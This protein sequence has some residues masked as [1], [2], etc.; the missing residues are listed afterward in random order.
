MAYQHGVYVQEIPTSVIPP[1]TA[2]S[3]VIFI[4]GTAPVNLLAD[5]AGAVNKLTLINSFAEAVEKLGYSDSFDKF[6]IC[7][8]LDA[9]FRVYNVAPIV[10][11]N[12]LDPAVH[13]NAVVADE[14]DIVAKKILIEEEGILFDAN[15][16]VVGSA[17]G[18]VLP[19]IQE[20]TITGATEGTFKLG[21]SLQ[22]ITAALDHDIS[23]VNLAAAINGLEG[24]A[25]A[26]VSLLENVY[27]ITYTT[28][29]GDSGIIILDNSLI[30]DPEPVMT[31]EIVQ[32]YVPAT[33][34]Y[35]KD[36]DYSLEFTDD[37]YA[38]L[39]VI[40]E[41]DGGTI[42]A[43]MT[44]LSVA[45]H[46]LD[47]T[48]VEIDDIIGGYSAGVYTGLECIGQIYPQLGIVPGL[49]VA[50]GWSQN[51]E[52]AIAMTAKCEGING[53]F[54]CNTILDIDSTEATGAVEYSEVN[55]WKNANSYTDRHNFVYWPMVKIGSKQYYF[56]AIMAALIAYTDAS[57]G[58]VPFVSPSNKALR[59][60]GTVL[61]DGT[62]VF[63]DQIQANYLNGLG[64]NTAINVNGWKSWGNNTGIYP[65]SS[66]PKDR[67]I[68]ARR[69][70]DFEG[71]SFIL[72]FFQKVDSPTNY[73][74]IESIVDS[75]NIARN[76]MKALGQI[77]DSWI[78]FD[79]DENPITDLLNG[80]I[81]FH[82]HY[83]P[84]LPAEQ[85]VN[86]LEFDP[87]ALT[88]ALGGD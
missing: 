8:L 87:T 24:F 51:P 71:N 88:T 70:F 45:Y 31:L 49:I 77:I 23:A 82:Q 79:L 36:Q 4:V 47:S 30:G 38:Q 11:V 66:D 44:E 21:V 29:Q 37:G 12:V 28:A 76:G 54:K 42:P 59:I 83:T 74:L 85:I 53:S 75:W 3:A 2:D 58:S 64:I 10:A 22:N 1:I 72:T 50:P 26:Q 5:P 9:A 78:E 33:T 52:V 18:G 7:Q 6:S 63:L 84:P 27:T 68:A 61:A 48:A 39:T 67:W 20:L 73:R 14:Y 69:M 19:E 32:A 81:T 43:E 55:A 65:S 41:E 46:Q 35:V 56:S 25:G 80:K 34:T 13:F 17:L 62:E 16:V 40:S 15:F 57:N 86:I 60:T